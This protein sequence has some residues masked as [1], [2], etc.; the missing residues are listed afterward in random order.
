MLK[1]TSKKQ[2]EDKSARALITELTSLLEK[3]W[4]KD[5]VLAFLT[6]YEEDKEDKNLSRTNP[7]KEDLLHIQATIIHKANAV[8]PS[9]F[10]LPTQLNIKEPETY[11]QAMSRSHT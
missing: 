7:T 11:K 3:N 10:F 9:N 5:Q 4:E 8:N 2:K 6:I 1:P